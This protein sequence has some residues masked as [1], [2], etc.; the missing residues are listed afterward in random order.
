[1]LVLL[2]AFGLGLGVRP[3]AAQ[4]DPDRCLTCADT[5]AHAAAGMALDGLVRG[6]WISHGW[7]DTAPKRLALVG[8]VAAAYEGTQWYEARVSGQRGRGY[9][10]GLKDWAATVI[11]AVALEYLVAVLWGAHE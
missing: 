8:V 7:R 9:G 6:P 11:G 3:S 2:A 1:M 10:F 5:W 4:W